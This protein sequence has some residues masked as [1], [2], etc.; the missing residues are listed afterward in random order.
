MEWMVIHQNSTFMQ[1]E[2]DFVY[3]TPTVYNSEN[4]ADLR[5]EALAVSGIYFLTWEERKMGFDDL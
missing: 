4:M 3:K 5:E 1:L 2:Y